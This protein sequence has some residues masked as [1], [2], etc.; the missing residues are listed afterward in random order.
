M[1]KILGSL[2]GRFEKEVK[3]VFGMRMRT[4]SHYSDNDDSEDEIHEDN[5]NESSGKEFAMAIGHAKIIVRKNPSASAA[6]P[7]LSA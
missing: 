7:R 6:F 5:C 3:S 2:I 4:N 1:S